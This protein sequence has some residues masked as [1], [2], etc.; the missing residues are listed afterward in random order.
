MAVLDVGKIN[1]NFPFVKPDL[2]KNIL[3]FTWN[4]GKF[5]LEIKK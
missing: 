3:H 4:S 1:L 2:A 5:M